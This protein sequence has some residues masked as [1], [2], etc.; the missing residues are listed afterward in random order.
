[1]AA[2]PDTPQSNVPATAEMKWQ[3]LLTRYNIS[4]AS[5]RALTDF[6]LRIFAGYVTLQA[7]LGAWLTLHGSALSGAPAAVF[8]LDLFIILLTLKLLR[9][10]FLR[11]IQYANGLW[12]TLAALRFFEAGTYIASWPLDDQPPPRWWFGW[13]VLGVIVGGSVAPALILAA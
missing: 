5:L 10:N 2:T 12:A 7:G 3:A 8:V 9:N 1:M 11:R 13:Y 4:A 6:D